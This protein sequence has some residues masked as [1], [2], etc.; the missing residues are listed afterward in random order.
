VLKRV[1]KGNPSAFIRK[2]MDRTTKRRQSAALASYDQA[3]NRDTQKNHPKKT[4]QEEKPP[5]GKGNTGGALQH[6]TP[7]QRR[8]GSWL[9]GV[10]TSNKYKH[11][12]AIKGCK[13]L[14]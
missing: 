9:S 5:A 1:L 8:R 13:A 12:E 14:L 7:P 11:T 2:A 10:A 6:K 4:T 3:T